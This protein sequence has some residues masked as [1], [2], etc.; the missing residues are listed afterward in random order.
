VDPVE[1]FAANVR[2]LRKDRG[3]TQEKLAHASGLHLTDVARIETQG[4]EPGVR[5]I[6]KLAVGL[7]VDPGDLFVGVRGDD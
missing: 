2:R 7:D 3:L 1:Q 4:R 6:A 5:V